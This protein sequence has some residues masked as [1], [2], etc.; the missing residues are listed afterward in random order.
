MQN[1]AL[2]SE[3]RHVRRIVRQSA[4]AEAAAATQSATTRSLLI[5][6][7]ALTPYAWWRRRVGQA[8]IARSAS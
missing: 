5:T 2:L 6:T 7:D 3:Q 1:G 4:A 8:S